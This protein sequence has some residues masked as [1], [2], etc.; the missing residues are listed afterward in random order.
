MSRSVALLSL[1]LCAG[2]ASAA[3]PEVKVGAKIDDL[4]FKDIRFLARSLG[5]FGD[6]KAYVLVF[7]DS[8]CPIAAKYL[9][10]LQR[11]ESAYRDKGVQFVAVNSGPN[12]TVVAMA[13]QAVAHG[14]EF[15]FVKDIDCRVA[16]ALG[17]KRT[18]EVV[19]LDAKRTLRYRGRID[20]Q[21]RPGG[22][23]NE[24]TRR[25]LV[26]ALDEVLAGKDVTVQTTAVDGCL[27]A[28]PP[29]YK[30]EK[31]VTFAE[32]V[33]PIL[34]KHCQ[35][36]HQP[37]TAAP[38][39]LQTYEQARAKAD[40]IAE[41]VAEGR[42]PPWYTVPRDGDRIQHRSLSAAERDT[43]VRWTKTGLARGDLSKL[44]KPP[45]EKPAKWVIGEPDL[46]LTTEPF[47]LPTEGD[48]K[49]QYAL[50][51]KHPFTEDTWV[52]GVQILP[53][54]PRAVH[55]ANLLYF[56]VGETPKE[57][58][59]ITGVVP[60]GEPMRLDDGVAYRIPKGTV[61]ALQ[62]H[63][64]TTGKAEKVTL[65]VGLKYAS[66][67]VNQQLHHVLL[68]DTK[69]AIP[70]GAPAHPVKVE[71]TLEHDAVGIGLF[72]HMHV[73]GKAMTFTAHTPDGRDETLLTVPNYNFEWQIPYRW[74]PG[75]KVLPK[76]TRLGCVALYDNSPFNP[77][78]PDP[79]KT[80]KNGDQTYEEMMNGFFFYVDANEKLGLD[81]DPK[82]GRARPKKE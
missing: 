33:A 56:K 26:E 8:G 60:G 72:S 82:T 70:P 54:V 81:I 9:P 19:V 21:Y 14:V 35:R 71:R 7:V 24:P 6:K 20:D 15:P 36:C 5:D 12:D 78:N 40:T 49:Y 11:L 52:Q 67:K 73:R 69:Y 32:H 59:F 29:S 27:I 66:G 23:R 50:F 38:F 74:E 17:V 65:S 79:K 68:V 46:V 62:I 53:D 39:A 57:S 30:D 41:V 28:R 42:M 22:Q 76:G 13:E 75:K 80:V 44:P 25:D 47:E 63:Y 4:R 31:P 45:E 1:L 43:V 55:H 77:Y 10:G 51:L 48:I 34:A 58:N 16:D 64:V 37:N 2:A 3:E 18:P 61:L